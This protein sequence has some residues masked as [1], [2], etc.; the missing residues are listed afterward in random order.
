MPITAVH[1]PEVPPVEA[2]SDLQRIAAEFKAAVLDLP[3]EPEEATWRHVCDLYKSLKGAME[4]DDWDE[5]L[6][7]ARVLRGRQRS[8]DA[9]WGEHPYAF[10]LRYYDVRERRWKAS[11]KHKTRQKEKSSEWR[12]T[13]SERARQFDRERAKTPERQAQIKAAKALY[14]LEELADRGCAM[15]HESACERR[16][17]IRVLG[18]TPD[19]TGDEVV[20]QCRASIDALDAQ[21]AVSQ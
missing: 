15:C 9:R 14:Q 2:K 19:V 3:A 8:K 20:A 12:K 18:L 21:Q 10:V 7:V 11:E 17:L 16:M 5:L 6:A 4:A 1:T 13:N